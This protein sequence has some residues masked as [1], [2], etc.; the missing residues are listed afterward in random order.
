MT[1]ATTTTLAVAADYAD[2]M[3]AARRA[4]SWLFL[5][6]LLILLLQIGIFVLAR[7]V[8]A[9][10]ITA[11]VTTATTTATTPTLSVLPPLFQQL[12]AGT[13]FLGFTLTIV[14]AVMLLLIL[15][16]MLV[17]RLVGVAHVTSAFVWCIFL[18]V[19]LFP[20]QTLLNSNAQWIRFT[21]DVQGNHAGDLNEVSAVGRQRIHRRG[22][23]RARR[24]VPHAGRSHSWSAL[25]LGRAGPRSQLQQRRLEAV[26]PEMDALRGNAGGRHSDIDERSGPEQPGT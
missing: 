11:N 22:S 6:L 23:G 26:G 18:L 25:Y 19:L 3:I 7:F 9:I 16:I 12:V 21:H 10:Q 8:P 4:K 14:L 13:D 20:W 15:T 24:A 5:I 2:A 17:G 1:R